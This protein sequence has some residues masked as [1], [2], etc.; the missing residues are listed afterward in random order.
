M[1]QT[2]RRFLRLPAV[3]QAVGLSRSAIYEKISRDEFPSPVRLG[4][5]RAVAWVDAEVDGWI[6]EQ[7]QK[8]RKAA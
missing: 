6:A 8:A 2:P 4:G 7:I 5:G 3:K 1:T